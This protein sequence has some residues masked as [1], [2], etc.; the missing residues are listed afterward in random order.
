[1]LAANSADS[2]RVVDWASGKDMHSMQTSTTTGESEGSPVSPL[3]VQKVV[4]MVDDSERQED[5]EEVYQDE[6][7]TN[8]RPS[9][10][11]ERKMSKKSKGK[12]KKKSK[13]ASAAGTSAGKQE[14][15]TSATLKKDDAE[16][17]FVQ[18]R[19][20]K[21][22]SDANTAFSTI[23]WPPEQPNEHSP[24]SIMHGDEA[25]SVEIALRKT[26]RNLPPPQEHLDDNSDGV[27]HEFALFAQDAL[28]NHYQK[29]G[30]APT[31]DITAPV[32]SDMSAITT[33]D[34]NLNHLLV[35]Y[36]VSFGTDTKTAEYLASTFEEEQRR[37]KGTGPPMSAQ[38]MLH[39]QQQIIMKQQMLMQQ[40]Q[41]MM[42]PMMIHPANGNNSNNS[43]YSGDSG[44]PHSG[45]HSGGNQSR[46]N[47]S[48]GNFSAGGGGGG[49]FSG[50]NSFGYSSEGHHSGSGGGSGNHPGGG[51]AF[52]GGLGSQ[53]SKGHFTQ[54]TSDSTGRYFPSNGQFS[55]EIHYGY[56]NNNNDNNNG[57]TSDDASYKP[58]PTTRSKK[59][60]YII[61]AVIVVILLAVGGGVGGALAGGGGGSSASSATTDNSDGRPVETIPPTMPPTVISNEYYNAALSLSSASSM[62]DTLSPQY[63]AVGWLSTFDRTQTPSFGTAFN[64][65][66]ALLVLYYS[67]RGDYWPNR[68]KWLD[69]NEHECEW[70]SLIVCE[71]DPEQAR[72]RIIV[73]M[74]FDG[75][76]ME[77]SIPEEVGLLSTL[78]SFR[79]PN[80]AIS[81]RLPINLGELS[82]LSALDFHDNQLT[83]TLPNSLANAK[84]LVYLNVAN[85]NLGQGIPEELFN[86][87]SLLR[88]LNLA[89]NNFNGK[90]SANIAKLSSL[91]NLE[92]HHNDFTGGYPIVLNVMRNLQNI[93]LDWNALTGDIPDFMGPILAKDTVSISHNKFRGQLRWNTTGSTDIRLKKVDVSHNKIAGNFGNPGAVPTLTYLD[94]SYN[95]LTGTIPSQLNL[96]NL[97]Y[98][99]GA[100]NDFLGTVPFGFAPSLSKL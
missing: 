35:E 45:N 78:A 18:P 27:L 71:L 86:S 48:G 38:Q 56:N 49:H 73:G 9:D 17:G 33:H 60:L 21:N 97:E 82:K 68:E 93:Q 91:A 12:K 39:Q 15:L 34:E 90:I 76:G 84:N 8:L 79:L 47:F 4:T 14:L 85:N 36:L 66:Y 89:F 20:G 72:V 24:T 70:S 7:A 2:P 87:L 62:K 69:P 57:R 3:A 92:I 23:V 5:G 42:P 46:G 74:D 41:Q 22:P 43:Q 100:S 29:T 61:I 65:R 30:G 37:K 31:I 99:K 50:G 10:K 28:S 6:A 51:G 53:S 54:D 16:W 1:M 96:P 52:S 40:Q 63:R 26:V 88:T 13:R 98:L 55:N 59:K 11:K 94:V 67:L 80:N 44:G 25:Q 81:G 64:Q 77:G 19:K 83:G 32:P 58:P 75:I 95:L